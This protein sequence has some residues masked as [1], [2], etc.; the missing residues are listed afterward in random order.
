MS[1]AKTIAL[2]KALGGGGGGGGSSFDPTISNPQDGDTLVYD[3]TAGKW[4]NGAASSGGGGLV[5]TPTIDMEHMNLV[6]DKTAQEIYDAYV[7]G[8]SVVFVMSDGAGN[9]SITSLS[10]L[11]TGSD[12]GEALYFH[13]A[14]IDPSSDRVIYF[15]AAT[16]SDYPICSL[17]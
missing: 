14:N 6:S 1:D 7:A 11:E 13:I 17:A 3:A 9:T 8:K 2:I 5:I 10:T 15:S 4:V 12:G 16:M